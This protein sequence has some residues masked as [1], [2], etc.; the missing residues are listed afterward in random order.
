MP[1]VRLKN[2]KDGNPRSYEARVI[3]KGHP[4]VSTSFPIEKAT[5]SKL[6]AAM[7]AAEKRAR[8]WADEAERKIRG[9]DQVSKKP[10][11]TT[12]GEAIEE[13]LADE[14][15]LAND[16]PT[17]KPMSKAKRYCL[18]N[19]KHHVGVLTVD[20]LTRERTQ[21]FINAMLKL[22][23]PPPANRVE[24]HPLYDGSKPRVYSQSTVR[25]YYFA[26]KEALVWHARKHRY[27]IGDKF[28]GIKVPEA[29]AGAR[30][31]RLEAGEEDRLMTATEGMYKS[32][33]GYRL[34]IGLA[35][36]TAMRAQELL[37]LLWSEIDTRP[38]HRF[39][40]LPKERTKGKEERQVSL[41]SKALALLARLAELR[42]PADARVFH[43]LPNDTNLLDKGFR[44]LCKRAE[45]ADLKFHDLRH[46]ATSRM[47]ERTELQTVEVMMITGHSQV[48]TL[49]R[50]ANIRPRILAEKLDGKAFST[51]IPDKSQ[52]P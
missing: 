27:P 20:G 5:A 30:T 51:Y 44:R 13:Y 1:S 15:R 22:E 52:K 8:A 40:L 31:R 29:W 6:D 45:I 32:P 10:E 25:K 34:L 17:H 23:I 36:E 39:I 7:K 43:M 47:F 48:D 11:K 19:V 38:D 2:D 12:I 21:K 24:I 35:L 33:E 42:A 50:Y 41:S 14:E 4:P 9:G 28:D 18:G 37:G 26:L 49:R 3:I 46:E 16:D